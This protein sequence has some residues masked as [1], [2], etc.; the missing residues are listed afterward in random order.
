MPSYHASRPPQSPLNLPGE[1]RQRLERTLERFADAWRRGQRPAIADYLAASE[2]ERRVLLGGLVQEDLQWRLR[3]GEEFGVEA[4]LSAYPELTD[5]PRVVADL[6]ALEYVLREQRGETPRLED[7]QA[8]FPQHASTLAQQVAAHRGRAAEASPPPAAQVGPAHAVTVK[9]AAPATAQGGSPL[10]PAPALSAVTGPALPASAVEGA[11]VPGYEVL[12]VLGKG[13]MGVVYQA[14]QVALDRVVALKMILNAEHAGPEER[15]RFRTEARAVARLQHPNIIQ[16]HEVGE[17]LGLPYFSLE[18]CTGGSLADQ[19]DGT[20]WE[21]PR[22]AQLVETLAGAMQAA[23][24]AQVVHRDLKPANVLLTAEGVAKI[25]DF[26]LAKKLDEQGQTQSGAILGT[27]SYMAPE[28]AGGKGKEIGPA[29]DVWALGAILYELLTGRPPFKAATTMDTLFQV[30]ADDPV[31]PTRLQPRTPRD[32]E[33]VCLK[34][35][36][37]DPRKRYLTAQELAADLGRFRKGEPIL[38]R[39]AG[40][41]ERAVKWAR[42]RPA[43]AAL[44]GVS[45]AAAAAVFLSIVIALLLV[46]RS[47]DDALREQQRAQ[48]LAE[49]KGL[50]ADEKGQLA[51]EKGALAKSFAQLAGQEKQ[52]R[53]ETQKALKREEEERTRKEAELRLARAHLLTG[54]LLR[55][56]AVIDQ[57][58][59]QALQLLH[60]YNACPIDLRDAAWH[61]YQAACRGRQAQTL[62]S[63]EAALHGVAFLRDGRTLVCAD[64]HGELT[65]RDRIT[66][67]ERT[68][69][70]GHRGPAT[71]LVL[72]PK[73]DLLA[74]VGYD[75]VR[76]WD[77]AAAKEGA[78]LE[79]GPGFIH[80]AAFSS[81]GR[82]LVAATTFQTQAPGPASLVGLLASGCPAPAWSAAALLSPRVPHTG[83]ALG[84]LHVWDVATARRRAL[85]HTG[86]HGLRAVAVS[87]SGAS[88]ITGDS[89]G[90]VR[91]WDAATGQERG[92]LEAHRGPVLALA[93]SPDGQTLA[94]G[95]SDGVVR[96]WQAANGQSRG[97]VEGVLGAVRCFAFSPDGRFLAWGKDDRASLGVGGFDSEPGAVYLLDFAARQVRELGKHAA[98][99]HA[100]AFSP[101]GRLL[102]SAAGAERRLGRTEARVRTDPFGQAQPPASA[103]EIRLWPLSATSEKLILTGHKE[104]VNAVACSPDG[105]A[106]ASAGEDKTVRLWDLASGKERAVLQGHT[107]AVWAVA[108]SPDGKTV[109]SAGEDKT[110]RLWDAAA[111][112]PGAVLSGH[113]AYVSSLAF[114]PDGKTLASG[115]A[116]QTVRL[117]DVA[118]AKEARVLKG[119][120]DIVFA[121]AFSRDGRTLASGGGVGVIGQPAGARSGR[122]NT[123]GSGAAASPG[124]V[125]LWDPATGRERAVLRGQASSV[126]CLAFS[127]D[128]STLASGSGVAGGQQGEWVGNEL[129]L[130]DVAA[131]RA[132]AVLPQ[133]GAP[134]WS[135]AFSPDGRSLASGGG[136]GAVRLRDALTGQER[137]AVAA[138]G[139]TSAQMRFAYGSRPPGPGVALR[140]HGPR[141]AIW[142]LA[143]SPDGRALIASGADGTIRVWGWSSGPLRAVLPGHGRE[144]RAVAFR[145]DGQVLATAGGETARLWEAAT[146]RELT[147][148]RGRLQPRAA[149]LS[150]DGKA[151]ACVSGGA[152]SLLDL[153]T[154][155]ER[156]LSRQDLSRQDPTTFLMAAAF[157]PDSTLLAV[158]GRAKEIELWEVAAARLRAAWPAPPEPTQCLA[159]S[160]DRQRLAGGGMDGR[161][162]LWDLAT[163]R[164]RAVFQVP[165]RSPPPPQTRPGP[166]RGSE[167]S[168]LPRVPGPLPHWQRSLTSLAFSPDGRL[169]AGG[170]ADGVVYV[171]DAATGK[172]QAVLRGHLGLVWALAFSPDGKVL[173]SG[174]GP[175]PPPRDFGVGFGLRSAQRQDGEVWLWDV[176]AARERAVLRGHAAAV[177]ALAFS[178]DGKTLVSG[179]DDQTVRLWEASPP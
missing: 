160:P 48:Q 23:H 100:L 7:Y 42:R 36:Q 123:P 112:R 2:I 149:A 95:G 65:W 91:I 132:R 1:A 142:S 62:V 169:L 150:S 159:F 70:Q 4:Y 138:Q 103:A 52:A 119:H 78:V 97:K 39:P 73:G 161:V 85:F 175:N 45:A 130:W 31:P 32:L 37:K 114:S 67:K 165:E 143:F 106:L 49:E 154:G 5:D 124:E 152:V 162:R 58:A 47:R 20:P 164:E 26:G 137:A 153:A 75:H 129:R 12:G 66:G 172:E 128:G 38:A 46:T 74:S 15:E 127:P 83:V 96:L 117:W 17:Y 57:D 177:R 61:Y 64:A 90:F 34:C 79:G 178:P 134:V 120:A 13:G 174:C 14:R 163:G 86:A 22:A 6:A 110:I 99:V 27:P 145:R 3:A 126:R 88:L 92:A 121:V 155:Q 104:W 25:T 133:P 93:F 21:A 108:Y 41:L 115:S 146:G 11:A 28:Q 68:R 157:H 140:G 60:D 8:R 107:G 53:E 125:R 158:A 56:R 44:L 105:T 171:W 111:G 9:P 179:S 51:E 29:A 144:V 170:T 102:A 69:L 147:V 55:V 72:S 168:A 113:A 40:R 94:S 116:D 156:D 18:L 173:A 109:A 81:D 33:T 87:P 71:S 148:F 141:G 89:E 10:P 19:L 118:G 77:A 63:Q 50:L 80:A 43:V 136:D 167:R 54:Q 101:D 135:V 59:E 176:A 30:L 24:R 82:T 35:L 76:L 84:S 166:V 122:V 98:A 139:P 151:L 16:V 131:G